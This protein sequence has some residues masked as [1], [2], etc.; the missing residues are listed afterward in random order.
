M[1]D[2]WEDFLVDTDDEQ[3]VKT[4]SS[5]SASSSATSSGTSASS[6]SSGSDSGSGSSDSICDRCGGSGKVQSVTSSTNSKKQT[7]DPSHRK[8]EEEGYSELD[9]PIAE[10]LRRQ[11]L[12]EQADAELMDDLFSGCP[13]PASSTPTDTKPTT[14]ASAKVSV[15]A[16]PLDMIDLKTIKDIEIFAGKLCEKIERSPAKSPAWLRLL[17]LLLK[18]CVP[19]MDLKDVS[20]LQNKTKQALKQKTDAKREAEVS[21]KKPNDT[22]SQVRNYKD[23]MDMFYGD[24]DEEEEEKSEAGEDFYAGFI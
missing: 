14:T 11:R 13:K 6:G 12:V 1:A 18:Q 10:K 16:D 3:T 24:N 5:T 21:K 7:E 17:D 15:T 20:T 22:G 9:D 8:K 2:N 23:E 4:T 19:K